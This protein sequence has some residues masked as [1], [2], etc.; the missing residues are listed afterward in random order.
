MNSTK[1][2]PK[3]GYISM[4][5]RSIIR[6]EYTAQISNAQNL[7]ISVLKLTLKADLNIIR[8]TNYYCDKMVVATVPQTKEARTLS[9]VD[10]SKLDTQ[11]SIIAIYQEAADV[12]NETKN[13]GEEKPLIA[14][15]FDRL[16]VF[17]F[18][19]IPTGISARVVQI[20]EAGNLSLSK[21]KVASI[22]PKELEGALD[23]DHKLADA[24]ILANPQAIQQFSPEN[25]VFNSK[26]ASA[27]SKE[28]F[29]EGWYI[30]SPE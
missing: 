29:T 23:K 9:K 2:S 30:S 14:N 8:P 17:V 10:F 4:L 3:S 12:L 28:D 16:R 21:K 7:K 13:G 19:T 22:D 20:D 25:I 5:E 18:S 24:T 26:N 1:V 27:L 6:K 15:T 11:S